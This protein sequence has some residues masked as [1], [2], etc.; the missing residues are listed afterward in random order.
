MLMA[1]SNYFWTEDQI[2][3]LRE[4]YANNGG[5]RAAANRIPEKTMGTIAAKASRM[6]LTVTKPRRGK[7]TDFMSGGETLDGNHRHQLG[8]WT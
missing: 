1:N 4:S 5:L 8:N 2:L 7:L 3:R 6:G